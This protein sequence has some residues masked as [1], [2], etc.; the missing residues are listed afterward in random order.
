[1]KHSAETAA[2]AAVLVD[3]LPVSAQGPRSSSGDDI[4]A[5]APG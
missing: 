3:R 1:M 4:P 5:M 2:M